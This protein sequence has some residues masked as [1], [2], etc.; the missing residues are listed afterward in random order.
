MSGVIVPNPQVGDRKYLVRHPQATQ[1]SLHQAPRLLEVL[2]GYTNGMKAL[3]K[4]WTLSSICFG[5][6]QCCHLFGFPQ[7]F[8][9]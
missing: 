2:W 8:L 6:F 9:Q 7:L 5:C 4:L 1:C 3:A